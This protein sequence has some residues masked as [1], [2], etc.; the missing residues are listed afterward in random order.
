MNFNKNSGLANKHSFLS[1]SSY[2]WVNYDVEKLTNVYTRHLALQRG[3]ELHEFA[4][5]CIDLNI[6]LPRT[7]KTLNMYVNDAIGFRM[8]PEVVLF[9][10]PY[11][12]G[13]VDAISFRENLLRI[14]DLKTGRTKASMVQLEV[15]A[16]LFCLEY[17]KQPNKID[18][19]LRIYQH[20]EIL[21]NVP[22]PM[23]IREIMDKIIIFDQKLEEINLALEN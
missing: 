20:G 16:A 15:Y 17:E 19:E 10:S 11:S 7:G 6:K 9:Y 1:P 21:V 4:Q 14:H 22:E 5:R 8:K 23:R 13:T 18:I 12:F 2:H 3:T